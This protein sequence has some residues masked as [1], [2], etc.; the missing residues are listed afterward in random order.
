MGVPMSCAEHDQ[1]AASTQF[2]THFTGRVLAEQGCEAT[3][4]DTVGYQSLCAIKDNTCKDSFDL[5]YGLFKYNP[6]SLAQLR[7]F[8][9]AVVDVE[10]QL[11]QRMEQD[12]G[13][14][15]HVVPKAS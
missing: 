10:A 4:I 12:E 9:Q 5:F 8:K 7:R 11:T 2:L 3:H 13:G 6:C 1:Q 14:T 15:T